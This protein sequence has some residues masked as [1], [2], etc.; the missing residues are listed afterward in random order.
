MKNEW[1]MGTVAGFIFGIVVVA[2]GLINLFWG[3]DAGFGLFLLLLATVYF[4][5]F[6]VYLHR[7]TG[8]SIHWMVKIVLGLFVLWAALGVGELFAK[9]DLMLK[10]F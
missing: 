7:W 8:F 1:S 2:I 5:T 4:P 6:N 3:N 9:I 10:H